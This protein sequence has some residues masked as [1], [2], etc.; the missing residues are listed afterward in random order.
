MFEL[1]Y[2]PKMGNVPRNIMF[3]KFPFCGYTTPAAIQ[4]TDPPQTASAP[5]HRALR[6][7]RHCVRWCA[8]AL[9]CLT[10][11]PSF[12]QENVYLTEVPDYE[13]FLGCFGTACGNLIGF[14]DRHGFPNFYTGPTGGGVAPLDSFS[15]NAGIISL[16][17]SKAGRDGRPWDK[18]GHEDDYWVGYESSAP[19]PYVTYGRPEHVPD[20]IGDFIGLNQNRWKNMNGECDGNI[21]GFSFNYWDTTG[22]RRVNFTPDGSA[23][24]P[25]RDL[26]SGLRMFAAYRGYDVDVFSQLVEISPEA[27]PGLGFTFEDLKAEIQAGYP[28]LIFLQDPYNKYQQ[29]WT[30]ERGNPDL[31]GV[32]AYGYLIDTDGTR[33]VRIRTSWASGDKE[34]REW[35]FITWMPNPWDYLPPRGVVGFHPKPRITSVTLL[36]DNL[37]VRWYGP[38]AEVYDAATGT[39]T[40]AHWYVV[41]RAQSLSAHDF[42]PIGNPVDGQEMLIPTDAGQAAFFRIKVI[43]PPN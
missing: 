20:C 14:W 26:Q 18:P 3:C 30:M 40:R 22:A 37:V 36:D 23:G 2:Q 35:A 41:E 32:L 42:K 24:L 17:A 21:D 29:R 31:H 4:K 6:A 27:S 1:D 19:D 11:A 43:P 13:W 25:T 16:W 5:V 28:V 10:L 8:L 7:F 39:R 33:Y 15:K 38:S 34:F 9:A 12:A